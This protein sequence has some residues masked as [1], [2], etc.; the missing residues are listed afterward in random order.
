MKTIFFATVNIISFFLATI[1]LEFARGQSPTLLI[2]AIVLFLV[3]GAFSIF[4][5]HIWTKAHKTGL[6]SREFVLQSHKISATLI[7][8][9]IVLM[10]ILSDFVV[11]DRNYVVFISYVTVY[12]ALFAPCHLI[13]FYRQQGS[14][15]TV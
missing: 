5:R 14:K 11:V 15:E 9:F 13:I 3:S 4:N 8:S 10:S 7:T 12:L 1:S 6:Q 2:F